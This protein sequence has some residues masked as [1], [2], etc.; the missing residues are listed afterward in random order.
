VGRAHRVHHDHAGSGHHE[1]RGVQ[2]GG[3]FSMGG[4][5]SILI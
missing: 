2:P 1:H 5:G 4:S 3:G